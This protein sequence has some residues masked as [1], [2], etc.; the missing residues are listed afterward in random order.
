MEKNEHAC[1]G[2][3]SRYMSVSWIIVKLLLLLL[4]SILSTYFIFVI[5]YQG[6]EKRFKKFLMLFNNEKTEA[7]K[8]YHVVSLGAKKENKPLTLLL[9]PFLLSEAHYA[10]GRTCTLYITSKLKLPQSLP[11]QIYWCFQ[12]FFLFAIFMDEEEFFPSP[13]KANLFRLYDLETTKCLYY[14]SH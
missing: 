14:L 13:P 9:C 5:W 2:S 7:L 1:F 12:L 3:F 4:F 8:R 10:R 6:R 11:T